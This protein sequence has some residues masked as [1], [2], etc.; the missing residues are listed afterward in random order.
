[1]FA[2]HAL[3]TFI[4]FVLNGECDFT[5]GGNQGEQKRSFPQQGSSGDGEVFSLWVCFE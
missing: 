4:N 3:Y 1:M 5:L 2:Q